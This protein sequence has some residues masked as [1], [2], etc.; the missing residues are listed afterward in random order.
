VIVWGGLS[1][2]FVAVGV[3][4]PHQAVG[5]LITPVVLVLLAWV[6]SRPIRLDV[7]E[8]VVRV[9]QGRR[10]GPDKQVPRGDITAIHYFPNKISFR[11]PDK[12]PILRLILNGLR[13]RF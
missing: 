10:S 8:S 13:G 2:V 3:I 11:G 12:E 1:G 7:T 9:R 5:A 4:W 6:R